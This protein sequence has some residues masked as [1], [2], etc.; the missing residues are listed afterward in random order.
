MV[1]LL[2]GGSVLSA[3]PVSIPDEFNDP[4]TG[5]H[6]VHVSRVPNDRSGVIYFTQSSFTADSGRVLFHTQFEDKWRHLYTFDLRTHQVVPLVT[7]RLTANQE[8]SPITNDVYYLA[9]H[10]VWS[11]NIDTR[12]TRKIADLP[13]DWSTGAGLSCN[14]NQ[15]LL[16][17]SAEEGFPTPI[18]ANPSTGPASPTKAATAEVAPETKRLS[19]MKDTFAAH[20]PNLLYTV[21]LKTGQLRV[22][23]RV[24]TWLGHVQFSPTDPDLLMFCHEGPWAKVDRIWTLRLNG[25]EPRIF[26]HRSQ[27]GEIAGHEFWSADGRTIWFQHRMGDRQPPLL[28]GQDVQSGAL[29]QF[30]VSPEAVAIHHTISANGK[31]FIGDGSG[32]TGRGPDKYLTLQVPDGN[33]LKVTKLCSLQNN[34]YAQCE[35]NPHISPDNHWI[36]FT[37]TLF[38]TPQAYAVEV[39]PNLLP[40]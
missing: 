12:R 31:F 16:L 24:N 26:F 33:G 5:L 18:P 35:P 3:D 8:F 10:A 36:V 14:A 21:D 39:P 1:W 40:R 7:D 15:T 27:P 28:A 6:L 22:I 23:H 34:D 25:G 2:I 29:T 17:G 19:S 38:G 9:D 11:T 13:L 4:E 20:R 37:A 32:K 30:V